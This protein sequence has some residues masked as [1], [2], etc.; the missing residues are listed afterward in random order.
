[1][2]GQD[3]TAD[4]GAITIT[5]NIPGGL[6]APRATAWMRPETI[7]E[8]E[9]TLDLLGGITAA[10]SINATFASFEVPGGEAFLYWPKELGEPARAQ[11][12]AEVFAKSLRDRQRSALDLM[13]KLD[14]SFQAGLA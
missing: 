13:R 1:M 9:Q 7:D 6:P 2:S 3:A 10:R 4:T 14:E 8:F 12:P 5:V 11:T